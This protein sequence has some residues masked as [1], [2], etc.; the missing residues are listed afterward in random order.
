MDRPADAAA[1]TR[2]TVTSYYDVAQMAETVAQEMHDEGRSDHQYQVY[3]DGR[4]TISLDTYV[5]NIR[6]WI[7]HEN[8]MMEVC[9]F[10]YDGWNDPQRFNKGR[11]IEHLVQLTVRRCT[12]ERRGPPGEPRRKKRSSRPCSTRWTTRMPFPSTSLL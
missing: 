6:V 5:P 10:R 11:W 8:L 4:L 3:Q 12:S 9:T 7:L 1:K 2:K